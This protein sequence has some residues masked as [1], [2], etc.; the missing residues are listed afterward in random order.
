VV[1]DL[2]GLRAV[3]KLRQQFL[4]MVCH[5]LRNPIMSVG[6]SL[7]LLAAREAASMGE[8]VRGE[9]AKIRSGSDNLA[10]LTT[11][12]LA[13]EKLES[14]LTII[15]ERVVSLQDACVVAEEMVAGASFEAGVEVTPP[16]TDGIVWADEERII[17]A[18][19]NMLIHAVNVSPTGSIVRMYI[20]KEADFVELQI[21]D[22]GPIV[23]A[24]DRPLI[25]ERF[26][27]A[28]GRAES[29]G[30]V[31]NGSGSQPEL[32]SSQF[33]HSTVQ[34]DS[35]QNSPKIG[36]GLATAKAIIEGHRGKVGATLYSNG[37][38]CMWMRLPEYEPGAEDEP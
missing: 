16:L 6:V 22:N 35:A 26:R 25:F 33:E 14:G 38:N 21:V 34:A 11:E 36:F 20:V 5:D 10:S 37:R 27:L 23:S 9:I 1:H 24:D 15:N 8:G 2:T 30:P 17:R 18:I 13:L 29:R 4:S 32:S 19:A 12:F 31:Q 7:E 3:E 28:R